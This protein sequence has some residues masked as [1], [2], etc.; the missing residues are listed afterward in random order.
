MALRGDQSFC[1]SAQLPQGHSKQV[2]CHQLFASRN[3][4]LTSNYSNLRLDSYVY[5][6][7]SLQD[8]KSH[9][10]P[11]GLLVMYAGNSSPFAHR[12][13]AL[14]HEVMNEE[15]AIFDMPNQYLFEDTNPLEFLSGNPELIRKAFIDDP[16]LAALAARSQVKRV[17]SSEETPT[18][19]WPFWSLGRRAIPSLQVVTSL[20][21]IGICL[22]LVR[23]SSPAGTFRWN[24]FFLGAGFMLL[25]AHVITK[26]S[27]LFGC[28][29]IVNAAVISGVLLMVILANVWV[30]RFPKV[31]LGWANAGLLVCLI[32]QYG[33]A[34]DKFLGGAGAFFA[35][36]FY[37]LPVI[38]AGLIFSSTFSAE[39]GP[40]PALG[41]NLFGSVVGGTLDVLS[42]AT[43]LRAQVIVIIVLYLGAWLTRRR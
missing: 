36:L 13:G 4:N 9:L 33:F 1:P 8:A 20:M 39:D 10:K 43:G 37:T 14:I 42:Y 24:Y 32:L 6:R 15:P 3:I 5:T 21:F 34:P 19:D 16:E 12:M 2:R 22:I 31:Y 30:L 18:D 27:L 7:E 35:V 25:E 26:M 40:G 17:P 11:G 38:F 28:T 23:F 29:W 41:A